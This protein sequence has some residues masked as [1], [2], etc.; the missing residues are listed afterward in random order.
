MPI[1]GGDAVRLM[2]DRFPGFQDDW[3]AYKSY[4]DGWG[5]SG[6]SDYSAYSDWIVKLLAD[7]SH[8]I[9]VIKEAFELIELLV[10]SGDNDVQTWATTCCL[11]H[12]S[13]F[14][15]NID[16]LLG[17]GRMGATALATGRQIISSDRKF[18]TA[19]LEMGGDATLFR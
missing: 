15:P 7:P 14:S 10:E 11:E 5:L 19:M 16:G 1:V 2:L 12:I 18:V 4:T 6:C 8:D 13:N 9:S 3:D 17:D